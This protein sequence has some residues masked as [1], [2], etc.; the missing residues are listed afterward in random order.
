MLILLS[1]FLLLQ[2]TGPSEETICSYL[3]AHPLKLWSFAPGT[4]G[5]RCLEW[6][7][8]INKAT[9]SRRSRRRMATLMWVVQNELWIQADHGYFACFWPGLLYTSLQPAA[10]SGHELFQVGSWGSNLLNSVPIL[11]EPL[12]LVLEFSSAPR[13]EH[14]LL[15]LLWHELVSSLKRTFP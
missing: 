14:I 4:S 9:R 8:G 11:A 6:P 13:G 2:K 7:R 5:L 12:G 3:F 15:T 1:E 10:F